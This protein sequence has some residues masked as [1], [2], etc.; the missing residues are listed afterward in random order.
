MKAARFP[1]TLIGVLALLVLFPLSSIAQNS[2]QILFGP[3]QF[4][5]TSGPTT[6]YTRTVTVPAQVVAPYTLHIVNG[7]P[8]TTS[9]RVAIED[10]VSSGR[11]F[12]NGVEVVSPN[13]FSKTTA[14]IEKTI[15]LSASNTL[16]VRLNSAPGSYITV[17]ISGIGDNR[18]PIAHAGPDQNVVTGSLVTLDGSLS[19]DPDGEMLTYQWT[20]TEKPA[21]SAAA[22]SASGAVRPTFTA[23]VDGTYRISLVVNDGMLNSPADEVVI[24]ATRPN[25][26]PTANAGPD[27]QVTA[28]ALVTLDGSTSFDPD[29]DLITYHW[30]FISRPAGSAA[31]FSSPTAVRPTF[32]ADLPGVYTVRLIVNDGQADSPPDEMVVTAAP[33]NN[34]PV[35]HAGPDQSVATGSLV[36][37]DGSGSSDPDGDPLTYDWRFVSLPTGSTAVLADSTTVSPAFT[38]DLSGEYVIQLIVSDGIVQSAVDIVVVVAAIPNAA[39]TAN[40]GPD[41]TVQKGNVVTLNGSGSFDPD[42]DALTYLWNFVSIPAGSGATL[43]HP[44]T[45]SP[46]FTAD[47]SGDYVIRLIVND[48]L[49]DSPPDSLVV[50]SVNDPPVADAGADQF[51]RVGDP[52][53]LNGSGSHD[54]NNDSLTYLWTIFSA[55]SGS[56]AALV[57]PTTSTPTLTPDLPGIYL[58]HLVVNDGEADSLPDEMALDARPPLPVISSISPATGPIGTAVTIAGLHFDPTPSNNSLSFNGTAAIVTS[59]TAT[60]ITTTVPQGATTGPVTVTT[61]AGS[62]S[63]APFTVTLSEDFSMAAAPQMISVVQG[64]QV[65]VKIQLTGEGAVPFEGWVAFSATPLPTGV[66]GSFSPSV[67]SL[68]QPSYLNLFVPSALAVGAYPITVRGQA[69]IDDQ[70]IVREASFTLQVTAAGMTTLSGQVFSSQT[71]RPLENIEV[72]HGTNS[73]LTDAAGNFFFSSIPAGDQVLLIDGTPATT[74]TVTYPIDLPVQVH[75]Q[76]GVSNR[77]PYPVYLHEIDTTH[78]TLLNSSQE[79]IVTDPDIPHFEL[80]VPTGVQIIGWDGQPNTK[81]AVTAVPI[82]RLPLPPPALSPGQAVMTVYMF[83]FFKPGGGIPTLPIPVKYPN[84]ADLPPGTK[85]DLF[86]YDEE[87][88]PDPNSH[89]WKTFGKGTVSSDGRQIVSDP[90][91]GIPKFCCGATFPLVVVP[92]EDDKQTPDEKVEANDP[93]NLANGMFE[94]EKTDMVLPGPIPVVFTRYYTSRRRSQTDFPFGP[95]TAHSYNPRLFLRGGSPDALIL[96]QGNDSRSPFSRNPDGTFTNDKNP[97]LKGAVI[98]PQSGGARLLRFKDGTKWFFSS[99]GHLTRIEDRNGN[100][101]D[102]IRDAGA[103]LLRIVALGGK[104][105]EFRYDSNRIASIL[106]PLGRRVQYGYNSAGNLISVI[107]P[108]GGIT[109]YTYDTDNRM[110]TLTDARGIT[111]LTNEYGPSN[112]VIRQINADGGVYQYRYFGPDGQALLEVPANLFSPGPTSRCPAGVVFLDPGVPA[113][114]EG[115]CIV[116]VARPGPA[117][118][119]VTQA[120]VV[121]PEGNP[122][123]YRFS[124]SGYL[125]ELTDAAGRVT[126]F[127]RA[128]GTNFLL[129][130]TDPAGRTTRYAY[131]ANGNVSGVTDPAGSVTRFT[132]EPAFNK[133]A[134]LT[135]PLDQT[136]TFTYD[137]KGNLL[138]VRDPMTKTTTMTYNAA[139]Q[140]ITVTDPLTHTTTFAYDFLGNLVSVI[141]PLGNVTKREY[142]IAGRL[143]SMT[144]PNGNSTQFTYDGLNRVTRITDALSGQT[145]FAYDGNGNLLTVTDAKNQTTRYN[146]DVMDRLETR[147]DPLN[148][149]ERYAYDLNGNLIRFTDRKNQVTEY[150][151]DPLKRRVFTQFADGAQV[152]S[153]YD[154]AGRLASIEDTLSGTIDFGYDTLD[155]L[156]SEITKQGKVEYQ[157]DALGRRT[158]MVVNGGAPVEYGYDANSRLTQVSQGTQVV[159][160]GYDDAGRR[161]SLT[162][163]NGTNT[164]YT[165][166][167]AGRLT[168]IFHDGPTSV[169]EDL[170]YTYDAAGNRIRIGRLGPE[171]PL[172][173]AVQAA[174]DAANE[175]IQF[176][177]GTPN[178]VYDANGNLISQT[179]A[180]GM[181]TYT[182]DAR[183]RL[184]GIAGP[185]V[186]ASFE[187]DVLG[188]RISKTIN[189]ASEQHQYDREDIIS[190]IGRGAVGATYVRSLNIDEPFI[191]QGSINEY[192]HADALGSTSTLTDVGGAVTI[193][194]SYE[195]FG[196]TI[197]S[198][199]S[200]N[201]YQYTGRENDGTGI[202]YYRARS[203]S[204]MLKRF[205]SEDPIGLLGEDLNLYSYVKGNSLRYRDPWGLLIVEYAARVIYPLISSQTAE[206]AAIGARIAEGFIAAILTGAGVEIPEY[207][208]SSFGFTLEGVQALG[209]VQTFTLGLTIAQ[210]STGPIVFPLALSFVGG[211]EVGAAINQTYERLR[212]QSLGEDIY[213]FVH[214]KELY[215]LGGRK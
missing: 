3:E 140:P 120:I 189:G 14:I 30:E 108:E 173:E 143:T 209:G 80:R 133:L 36:T 83:H 185:G 51:G 39:P 179:N 182:W 114:S 145:Q 116:R 142:D 65:A 47:R 206:E 134:T 8:N 81:I 87:P 92:V 23:D 178:L 175:Q 37:L 207:I 11:V 72:K 27:Q 192:F 101:L 100:A 66:V 97:S 78:V 90:G 163:P 57:A 177:A 199:I 164:S 135:D 128:Q 157:Y 159:G 88:H 188:R 167:L 33:P 17:T 55:P 136:T 183:N 151:Y 160:L 215:L 35:A 19:S 126:R 166:D 129:S 153:L 111:Y 1:L 42:G 109:R 31:V 56:T 172:P 127:E 212:G 2:S 197:N 44:A 208:R 117:D 171:A 49:A 22:L 106:D 79:V 34:P 71:G 158:A 131:D 50:I 85:L 95:G 200:S 149:L 13:A 132:Y 16:E 32:T 62:A 9:N 94:M 119:L 77:L 187:Y 110:I 141:D 155:R 59:A 211:I 184:V 186:S 180:G 161:T 169:I 162:Y 122:T 193:F 176:N 104:E 196:K 5:R 105:I 156:V 46:T 115:A 112:R 191:R 61:P 7:N 201:S 73:V 53:Q 118:Y 174:Y 203:Y 43:T 12:I 28:G 10:A 213:D 54:A 69:E 190:E 198:G 205:I 64:E 63:S 58:I 26:P 20:M 102:L 86:Y 74:D 150:S 68:A 48:G 103:R 67:G 124:S 6:V 138:T 152:K 75:L 89:Q 113:S 195:A 194:Y 168:R 21:G 76:T 60:Q 210:T 45:V 148:R 98:T 38:A 52:V 99:I 130:T 25:T 202:Y 4:T 96:I 70:I 139:G 125:A 204:T 121:D 40:A 18:A 146:Y 165:Y 154:L 15:N 123:S 147:T 82:D 170:T 24:I 137:P 144:D 181:T 93:V 214:R 29:G 107:D 41:Q 91:V 84:E